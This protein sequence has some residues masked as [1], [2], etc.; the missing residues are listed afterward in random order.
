M[1]ANQVATKILAAD[2]EDFKAAACCEVGRGLG[3]EGRSG[4]ITMLH[5][6]T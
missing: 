1:G 3:G 4:L 5:T 2:F 6:A